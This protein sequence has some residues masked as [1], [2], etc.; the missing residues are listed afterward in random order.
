MLVLV[1]EATKLT[2]GIRARKVKILILVFRMRSVT[3]EA[4]C[5]FLKKN[6]IKKD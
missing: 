4:A 1:E 5:A 6:A 3:E 2:T